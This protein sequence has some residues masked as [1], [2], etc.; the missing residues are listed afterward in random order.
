[1]KVLLVLSLFVVA[2]LA[3]V[4]ALPRVEPTLLEFEGEFEIP[5]TVNMEENTNSVEEVHPRVRRA[6]CDLLSFSSKWVTVNHSACAAHCL[7][8]R[9]GY[10]GG[11][12]KNTVCHCRK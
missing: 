5:E 2:C 12:C 6:T 4:S 7:A 9:R 10:K 8:L 3:A 11:Y 1:M